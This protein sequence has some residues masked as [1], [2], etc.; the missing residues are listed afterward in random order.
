MKTDDQFKSGIF[1]E[2]GALT[3]LREMEDEN[4]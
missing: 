3:D 1:A 2:H 4:G